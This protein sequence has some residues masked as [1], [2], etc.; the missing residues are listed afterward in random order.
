MK[1]LI[2]ELQSDLFFQAYTSDKH[3]HHVTVSVCRQFTYY[4]FINKTMPQLLEQLM[5]NFVDF[6]KGLP[7]F[8]Y[9]MSGVADI[10]YSAEHD[11]EK[12]YV[13]LL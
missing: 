3:S 10:N 5:Q 13:N 12:K 2:G 9:D 6:R 11:F 1:Y 4:D 8:F 7:S